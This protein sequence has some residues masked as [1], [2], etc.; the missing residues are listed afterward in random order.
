MYAGDVHAKIE[1]AMPMLPT[2]PKVI[3]SAVG[4]YRKLFK[5]NNKDRARNI[6]H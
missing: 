6:I 2:M 3:S 5:D 1:S 4:K